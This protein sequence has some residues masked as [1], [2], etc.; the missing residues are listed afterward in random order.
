MSNPKRGEMSLKLGEKTWSARITLDAI[1]K[2][3][4]ALGIGIVK[5]LTKLTDGNLTTAEMISILTP[6]IRGGG[7]DVRENDV[8]SIIWDAGLA[9]S[10]RVTGEVLA[11]AL[12]GGSNAGNEKEVAQ[13]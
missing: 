7:N 4:T 8:K 2:I 3:E 12:Q 13:V 6:I 9:N 5:V 10:M 11:A 1:I